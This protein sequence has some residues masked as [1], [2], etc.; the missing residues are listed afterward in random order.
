MPSCARLWII[1]YKILRSSNSEVKDFIG[2]IIASNIDE[3]ELLYSKSLKPKAISWASI[4]DSHR[5]ILSAKSLVDANASICG[6]RGS[7]LV[8][9]YQHVSLNSE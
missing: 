3:A 2:L 8:Y 7:R 5:I 6:S 4:D 1:R 9:I